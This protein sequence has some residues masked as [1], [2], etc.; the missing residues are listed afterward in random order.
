VSTMSMGVQR[1]TLE[2]NDPS[3]RQSDKGFADMEVARVLNH[4]LSQVVAL[5]RIK[6]GTYGTCSNC[7]GPI[8]MERFEAVPSTSSCRDCSSLGDVRMRPQALSVDRLVK[9]NFET[10]DADDLLSSGL[11]GLATELVRRHLALT[12]G[13]FALPKCDSDA[14]AA[15]AVSEDEDSLIPSQP[16]SGWDDALLGLFHHEVDPIRWSP[17][18]AH[19]CEQRDHLPEPCLIH[20]AA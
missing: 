3:I 8:E 4:R 2:K 18:R 13:L 10:L 17:E 14:L 11:G 9:E 1:A 16:A 12:Q 7:G 6:D 19:P 5:R 15:A 20:A